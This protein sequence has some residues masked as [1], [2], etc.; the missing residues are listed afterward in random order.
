MKRRRV[1]AQEERN[2][3][4]GLITNRDFASQVIPFLEPRFMGS[5]MS[6]IVSRWCIEYFNENE[7]VP[8]IHFEDLYRGKVKYDPEMDEDLEK[9]LESFLDNLSDAFERG[10]KFKVPFMVKEA[11]K[12]ITKAQIRDLISQSRELLAQ[13]KVDDAAKLIDSFN[14]N[15]VETI[16]GPSILN[17]DMEGIRYA[18]TSQRRPLFRLPGALGEIM[19]D[20]LRRGSFVS[21]LGREKIGKTFLLAEIGFRSLMQRCNTVLIQAGDMTKE[22][23]YRRLAIRI[24]GKSDRERYC[25]DE[26]IPVLDC[27]HNQTDSCELDMRVCDHGL[28]FEKKGDLDHFFDDN[29]PQHIREFVED[30]LD[31]Y[32]VPCTECHRRHKRNFKGSVWYKFRAQVEPLDWRTAWRMIDQKFKR[33]HMPDFKVYSYP[34]GTLT[35]ADIKSFLEFEYR[36]SGYMVDTLLIDYMDILR[37]TGSEFRH[38]QNQLWLDIRSLAQELDCIVIT[39]TQADAASYKRRSLNLSNFTED[40]RKYSHVTSFFGLNQ[41]P[42]E[43]KAGIIRVNSLLMRDADF[44]IDKEANVIQSLKTGQPIVASYF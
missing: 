5:R 22:Q 24:A 40:K 6:Q 4:I 32:Y 37:A 21:F 25:G 14:L 7:D 38:G 34:S 27:W 35:V 8:G 11:K 28:G 3:L 18:F 2:I 30:S 20:D 12:H 36:Q 44:L 10:Q 29:S 1:S 41:Q 23:Q 19:N 9:M 15:S 16:N 17:K 33:L 26:F 42:W 13:N 31:G 43:K 39:A